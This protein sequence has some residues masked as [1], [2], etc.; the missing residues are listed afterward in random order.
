[1]QNVHMETVRTQGFSYIA[2]KS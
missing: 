2:V 1:M